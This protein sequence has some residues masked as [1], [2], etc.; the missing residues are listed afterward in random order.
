[1]RYRIDIIVLDYYKVE[2]VLEDIVEEIFCVIKEV[3][4]EVMLI[5]KEKRIKKVKKR[6]F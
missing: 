1:M 4:G 2:E 3:G 6:G 5:R